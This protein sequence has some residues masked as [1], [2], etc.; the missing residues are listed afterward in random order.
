MWRIFCCVLMLFG[1]YA[2]QLFAAQSTLKTALNDLAEQYQVAIIYPD[3][4]VSS[5]ILHS[6]T[7]PRTVSLEASLDALLLKHGFI[8]QQTSSG[9][10]ISKPSQTQ[11]LSL[12]QP[13]IEEVTVKGD[14]N[15]QASS[16]VYARDYQQSADYAQQQKQ[17]YIGEADFASGTMLS[18][19][20]AE[21]LAEALQAIPGVSISRDRGEALNINAM[22]L[23]PEY[24]LTLLNGHRLAN[25]ENVRNSNQYGQQYRFDTFSAELFSNIAVY[26]LADARLPSGAAGATVNLISDDPLSFDDDHLKA[27]L[28]SAA[29]AGERNFQPS[30]GLIANTISADNKLAAVVKFNYENRLQR[31]FQFETWH[32]GNNGGAPAAYQWQGLEN[33]SLVPTDTLALTIEHEDRTRA[34]YYTNIAWQPNQRFELNTLWLRSDTDF[35]YDEH[36]LSINPS[37]DDAT[38]ILGEHQN[39]IQ[40]VQFNAAKSKSSR[41]ESGLYYHTQ[42]LQILPKWYA[43]DDSHWQI[44]P[45]YSHSESLSETQTP[46]TRAHVE[47]NAVPAEISISGKQLAYYELDNNLALVDSY[48]Q[49]SQLS[50]R[51]IEVNDEVTE[52]GIDS[53]WQISSIWGLSSIQFGAVKSTHSHQYLRQDVSLSQT[54]LTDLPALDGRWLEPL[55]TAFEAD[56]LSQPTQAWLIPKRDLLQLYDI[57]LPFADRQANDYLNS[58]ETEFT[59]YESYIHSVW[60]IPELKSLTT[61]FGLRHSYVK[62]KTLGHQLNENS[63]LEKLS[64]QV[65]ISTWLPSLNFKW[66]LSEQWFARLGYSRAVN[67]PNYSD[68][69]PKLHVNSG[70]LPYAELGNPA[71]EPVVASTTSLSFS[72]SGEESSLQLM[73]F[74]HQLDNFIVEQIKNVTYQQQQYPA[75]QANNDGQAAISGLQFSTDLKLPVLSNA[76]LQSRMISSVSQLL[77]AKLTAEQIDNT[78]IEGVSELTANLRLLFNAKK[79]Q[80]AVNLNY[81]SDFLEQR[82]LSNNADVYVDD[83]T[84]VDLSY[85]W[86]FSDL[87]ALRFDI[88]N[89]TDKSLVREVQTNDASSLMKVEQFGRRFVLSLSLTL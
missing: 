88:F 78:D 75:L 30:F 43:K 77:D 25:T 34:S 61:A 83:F 35:T 15:N 5:V 73:A 19:L 63:Q 60:Q 81:R 39:S 89:A 28:T 22:G 57:D 21:N 80:S 54:Q 13:Y 85:S 52:W 26:K 1:L 56:F 40:T 17:N 2:K 51:Q 64:E 86:F 66:Q 16:V 36:R 29:L 76:L 44:S 7:L 45:F 27:T 6:A 32:W 42:T 10:I 50:R 23:G 58:Y 65:N 82:D 20:P 31:Q 53:T 84:S 68:L 48:S 69:N 55:N 3:N 46:I 74:N 70:G 41:E 11:H 33:N 8:W 71:L 47:L 49:L 24:Q 72:W 38:A 87:V 9:I 37:S 62:S 67:R 4:L 14:K 79:W 12:S 59:A 18:L